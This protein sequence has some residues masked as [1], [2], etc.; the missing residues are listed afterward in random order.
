MTNNSRTTPLVEVSE[1]FTSLEGEQIHTGIPTTYIRFAR[2][3]KKC[4]LWNNPPK[5]ITATGY[6]PISFNPAEYNNLSSL[7]LITKGCDSQYSVSTAFS[8]LWKKYD[9]PTILQQVLDSI[10]FHAWVHPATHQPVILSLTGGEPTLRMKFIVNELLPHPLMM[11][12]KHILFETNCSVPLRLQ[13]MNKLYDWLESNEC[14]ITWSNSPKLSDSGEIW[15]DSIVPRIALAQRNE[16]FIKKYPHRFFQ[17]FKFVSDGSN[18]VEIKKAMEEYYTGG[19][20]CTSEVALMPAAC[21]KEQQESIMT[22]LANLCIK[23]GYRFSVRLQNV[24]WGNGIG[25]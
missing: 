3:N 1:I 11:G 7:P 21:S 12:C 8:H 16:D 5:E 25:T 9:A 22:T 14:A 4:P 2:C 6:A 17:Y 10:P 23:E 15:E 24:L 18:L 13:D 20:P 19:I